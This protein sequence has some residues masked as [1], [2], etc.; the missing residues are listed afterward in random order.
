LKPWLLAA[1]TAV[2][3]ALSFVWYFDEPLRKTPGFF[4]DESSIAYNA[5]WIARGGMDEH[6]LRMPVYFA[7]FGEYK[8][9]VYI[10]LLALVFKVAGPSILAARALSIALGFL[11]AVCLSSLVRDSTARA[12]TFLA[13]IATPWLFE[14]SRLVF[15]VAA[16]PLALAVALLCV[17]SL[18]RRDSVPLLAACAASLAVVTYTYTAGRF[19]GPAMAIALVLIVP[20]R[21]AAIA[22]GAYGV[23]LVPA[24]LN[25]RAFTAR[26]S[27]VGVAKSFHYVSAFS[28]R[29]L[30]VE[31]DANPRH[32]IA[33]GG[34]LLVTVALAA[35]VGIGAAIRKRDTWSRYLLLMLVLA[36]IPGALAPEAPH[37]LRL[38]TIG[39][40][41]VVFAGIGVSTL[42]A[43][44]REA[45]RVA[46]AMAL[47]LALAAEGLAFR[48]KFDEL[49]PLRVDDFD[50]AY[51][52]A[53]AAALRVRKP[54]ICVE[55]SP[56]F[57]HAYWYGALRGIDRAQLPRFDE[58][59]EPRGM[60]CVGSAPVCPSCRVLVDVR[61]FVVYR[62]E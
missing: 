38:I 58:G 55:E 22:W 8:N 2:A 49:G 32:H 43:I 59:T 42:A 52:Y 51:P 39:V 36:P 23:L 11:A 53:F 62:R 12:F 19:I 31:G 44:P 54:P 5:Y 3:A 56:Y 16:F 40:L 15:E 45:L 41:I 34:M 7:A 27:E 9:P 17:S 61:G 46:L 6:G 33:F 20:W 13:A 26:L 25:F 47:F 50:A 24:L 4:I 28:P 14:A 60:V 29:F 30:F 18:S 21:R 57:I 48:S 1:V 10:Y 35:L 37:A